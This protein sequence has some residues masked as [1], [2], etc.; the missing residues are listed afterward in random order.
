MG[1]SW[2][3]LLILLLVV[4]VIFG[5]KKLRNIGSDLGGAVKDFK[6]AMKDDQ[7]K[8][9][10]FKKISEEVEQTSVENSKQKEQA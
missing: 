6:K 8:D 3:Q 2:Q 1:S 10:E 7:P 4:V 5:T 9:A